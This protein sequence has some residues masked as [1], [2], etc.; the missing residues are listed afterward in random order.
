MHNNEPPV[1]EYSFETIS[2]SHD[3]IS[4]VAHVVLLL[5]CCRAAV[6]REQTP[7]GCQRR[8][9]ARENDTL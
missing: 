2:S 4:T 5:S 6:V 1:K 3:V 7:V 9:T 8:L